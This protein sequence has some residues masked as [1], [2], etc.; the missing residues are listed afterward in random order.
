MVYFL[1]R[2]GEAK[3]P[4]EQRPIYISREGQINWQVTEPRVV[5]FGRARVAGCSSLQEAAKVLK[6]RNGQKPLVRADLA[7]IPSE[8]NVYNIG[9]V[10]M[11]VAP[12]QTDE[13]ELLLMFCSSG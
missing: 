11:H 10:P 3:I 2:V 1:Y 5:T 9:G 7:T 12:L 13:L 8:T 4:P 6:T